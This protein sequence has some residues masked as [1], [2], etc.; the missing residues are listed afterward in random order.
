MDTRRLLLG[1]WNRFVRDPID[2]LRIA[3]IG[4]TVVYWALGRS[5][6]IGLT[7]ASI[8]LVIARLIDLPRPYDLMLLGAMVLIAGGTALDLYGRIGWYDKLV[9]G[10]SPFMWAPALYIVCVRLE[11]LPDLGRSRAAHHLIGTFLVTLALGAA[12]GAGYEICEWALDG[13]FPHWHLVKGERDTATDLIA[14]FIGA[15]L[16][17]LSLVVWSLWGWGTVRRRPGPRHD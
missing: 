12:V 8:V 11:V 2:V 16:G 15:A 13:F 5:T 6:A 1:D 4:G 3:F 10:L 14:D 17:G 7:A 9:H